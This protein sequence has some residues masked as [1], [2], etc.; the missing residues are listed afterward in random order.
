MVLLDVDGGF[1]DG[2][3]LHGANLGIGHV[4]AA[5]AVA[6]HGVEL[7]QRGDLG[8]KVLDGDV[9]LDG[10]SG[11]VVLN[12]GEELVERRVKQANGDGEALHRLVDR[13]EVTTLHRQEFG[14]GSLAL[15]DGVGHDHFADGRD[16]VRLK[17]HVFGAAQANTF[18]TELAGL[19]G[20]CRCVSIGADLHRAVLIGPI[21]DPTEFATDDG[22]NGINLFA[23]DIAS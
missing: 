16:A 13:L 1:D 4:E 8:F 22:G 3:G 10:K 2:L 19:L 14:Q 9:H 17:E 15:F 11:D 6:H 12:C 7:V 20:I 5:T 18:G 23:I 21:H